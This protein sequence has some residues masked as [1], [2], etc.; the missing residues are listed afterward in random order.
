MGDTDGAGRSARFSSPSG[1]ALDAEGNIH[2]A[3]SGNHR[4]RKIEYK[5]PLTGGQSCS[6]AQHG[7][8]AAWLSDTP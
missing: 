7:Q 8:A 4:I 3:D 6:G 5:L 2:V 1:L